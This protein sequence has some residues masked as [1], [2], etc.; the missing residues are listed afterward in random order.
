MI[1]FLKDRKSSI[2]S[3]LYEDISKLNQGH[4]NRIT[5]IVPRKGALH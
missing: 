4:T 1:R 3:G 2:S 5:Q